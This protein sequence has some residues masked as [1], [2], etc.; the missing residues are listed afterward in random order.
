MQKPREHWSSHLG[1]ILAAAGSAIGLGT[2]WQVPYITGENGGGAFVLVYFLCT[3]LIGVPVFIGELIIGRR[4]QR[5]A[6]S[7]F[8]T[9][10]NNTPFWKMAGWLGVLSSFL[11]MSFYSVIAGWGLNYVF[12]CLNQFYQG[13]DA[14]QIGAIFELL[15]RSWDITLFWHLAFTGLTVAVVYL[16]IRGGIEYWSKFMMSTLF[17]LL[18]GLTLYSFTL[19][20]FVEALTFLFYPDWSE[21][22]THSA[23]TALGLSFFTLSVAQGVMITYGSYMKKSEDIPQTGLIIGTMIILVAALAGMMI[24]PVIFT[25]HFMPAQGPGLVFKTLPLLFGK[26][27]G[28]LLISTTFFLLFVFA[29]LTSSIALVE[30]IVANFMDLFNWSRPKAVLVTGI[31]CFL[32]GIPSALSKT[33]LIF[34]NWEGLY[35]YTFFDTV[36]RLVNQWTMP[37][38]GLLT[39]LFIGW[40]LDKEAA[41]EEF[42]TG[43]SMGYLFKPWHFFLKWVSP[44]AILFIL[45]QSLGVTALFENR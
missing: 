10:S 31:A 20:G 7:A 39:A 37:V 35:G 34:A 15:E 27:P 4:S 24:F 3:L 33:G 14:A 5:S 22:H 36:S 26:L 32:F 11:I 29:A 21:F 30:V 38:G 45:L 13:K 23:L 28:A 8:E 42:Q 44:V 9:L 43:S 41:R 2:L 12:M 1:F 6:V 16:G 19:P 18:L 17:V 25:Y 40:V